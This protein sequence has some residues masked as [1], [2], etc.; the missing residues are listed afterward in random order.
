MK[1]IRP[2]QGSGRDVHR[3]SAAP[4]RHATRALWA[5]CA[6]VVLAIPSHG[7]LIVQEDFEGE[8]TKLGWYLDSDMD[9]AR[10]VVVEDNELFGSK[11]L[12]YHLT[13]TRSGQQELIGQMPSG[14]DMSLEDIS[15]VTVQFDFYFVTTGGPLNKAFNF[16]IG[17]SSG[18]PLTDHNQVGVEGADDRSFNA[19]IGWQTP[20]YRIQYQMSVGADGH[21]RGGTLVTV[22]EGPYIPYETIGTARMT[23]MKGADGESYDIVVEYRVGEEDFAVGVTGT[24]AAI[25]TQWDQVLAGFGIIRDATEGDLYIDNVLVYTNDDLT[26]PA[27]PARLSYQRVGD[28]LLLT[29]PAGGGWK[30]QSLVTTTT[31]SLKSTQW[32]D[33]MGAADGSYEHVLSKSDGAVVFFRLLKP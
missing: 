17:S 21:G 11:A 25:A 24:Y 32:T 9:G 23:L 33:V 22:N 20:Y 10:T 19:Y 2:Q 15:S 8:T 1:N 6:L 28:K 14:V 13:N 5:G 7:A 18:T 29:W 31:E 12:H 4:P 27:E 30:L 26:P 3:P 16:G